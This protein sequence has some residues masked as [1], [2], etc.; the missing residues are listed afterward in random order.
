MKSIS[1]FYFR[2][3]EIVGIVRLSILMK[4]Y[5]F[6]LYVVMFRCFV[7]GVGGHLVMGCM[8]LQIDRSIPIFVYTSQLAFPN[9][10]PLI[11]KCAQSPLCVT[12]IISLRHEDLNSFKFLQILHQVFQGEVILASPQRC[13]DLPC[14]VFLR[15]FVYSVGRH[16][17]TG[18]MALQTNRSILV[19]V[20]MGQL[21][22]PSFPPSIYKCA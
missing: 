14:V 22:F 10:P 1:Q 13:G 17:M 15:C 8:A 7:Q 12:L 18:Y 19:L 2:L 6:C 21:A 4:I 20:C 16:L 11:Q 3:T 5:L 9:Y